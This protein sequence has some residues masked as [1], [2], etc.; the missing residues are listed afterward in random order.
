MSSFDGKSYTFWICWNARNVGVSTF[1]SSSRAFGTVAL[2]AFSAGSAA[3]TSVVAAY[4][5][6]V[7]V[8]PSVVALIPYAARVAWMLR[9]M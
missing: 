6:W 5:R 2:S 9:P 1:G 8:P 3:F 7:T 4:G